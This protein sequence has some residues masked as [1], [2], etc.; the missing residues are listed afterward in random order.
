MSVPFNGVL[1]T[2][3]RSVVPEPAEGKSV[4]GQKYQL[5]RGWNK[6]FG[7]QYKFLVYSFVF[8]AF[9]KFPLLL[10]DLSKKGFSMKSCDLDY[11]NLD[12]DI[13]LNP[14]PNH[15]IC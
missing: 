8:T 11:L 13:V 10:S 1:C 15:G 5:K 9:F 2:K 7:L 6:V 14:K 4:W 12:P 3:L